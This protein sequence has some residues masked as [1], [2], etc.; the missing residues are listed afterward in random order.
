MINIRCNW[1]H[2]SLEFQIK[3]LDTSQDMSKSAVLFR[4]IRA[5]DKVEK[6]GWRLIKEQLS[7]VE[8]IDEAPAFTNL[9]A[10]YDEES[11]KI[12]E[13]TKLRIMSDIEGLKILQVQYMY[14][15]L[16][17]NYLEYL[18]KKVLTVRADQQI[19]VEDINIPEMVKLLVEMILLDKD[20]D[21]LKKIKV[22]LVD[23]R[24]RQ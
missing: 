18:K 1:R 19:E 5:A 22:I 2:A 13:R 10:K 23:W 7:R 12:L 24:N 3:R 11:A 20:S 9:Q 21:D 14:Q 17:V 4:M 8:K 16:Q 6:G 15:L